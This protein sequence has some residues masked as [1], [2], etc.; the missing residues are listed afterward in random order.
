M[1]HS[2]VKVG[3]IDFDPTRNELGESMP[4]VTVVVLASINDVAKLGKDDDERQG[5]GTASRSKQ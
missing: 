2:D 3:L 1:L 4:D 5:V